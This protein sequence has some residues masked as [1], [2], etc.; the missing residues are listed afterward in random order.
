MKA[1]EKKVQ[2]APRGAA[3]S[4]KGIRTSQDFADMMSA[5]IGDIVEGRVTPGVANSACRAG[6]TLLKVV[7]M[8]IKYGTPVPSGDG[9]RTLKLTSDQPAA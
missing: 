4:A 5:L 8:Q 1:K 9:A 7:E 6:T 2:A 3:L